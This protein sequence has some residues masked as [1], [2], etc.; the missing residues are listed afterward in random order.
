LVVGN[1]LQRHRIVSLERELDNQMALTR[2]LH[3][4]HV[5]GVY[6]AELLIEVSRHWV[7][8]GGHRDLSKIL[9][10]AGVESHP[11]M[12]SHVVGSIVSGAVTA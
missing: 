4:L 5:S 8:L 6:A 11:V 1:P 9:R 2:R 7:W 12:R 10:S 3:N